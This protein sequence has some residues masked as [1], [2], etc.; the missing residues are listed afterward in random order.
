MLSRREAAGLIVQYRQ[1][2]F[3]L[4]SHQAGTENRFYEVSKLHLASNCSQPRGGFPAGALSCGATWVM[5][6]V[7]SSEEKPGK[8]PFPE[9]ARYLAFVHSIEN[10]IWRSKCHW[11]SSVTVSLTGNC[12]KRKRNGTFALWQL[13]PV[14]GPTRYTGRS[15][16]LKASPALVASTLSGQIPWLFNTFNFTTSN[17]WRRFTRHIWKET[18]CGHVCRYM[19]KRELKQVKSLEYFGKQSPLC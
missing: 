5:Q 17:F 19:K 3:S 15:R 14:P 6:L 18:L 16:H 1:Q 11:L 13:C 12:M 10:E 8:T 4:A 7:N 9:C 2:H